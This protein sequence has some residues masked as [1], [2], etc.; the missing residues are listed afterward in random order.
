MADRAILPFTPPNMTTILEQRLLS[1]VHRVPH[2]TAR[3]QDSSLPAGTPETT[4]PL[5]FVAKILLNPVFST[6]TMH[7]MRTP[8]CYVAL[9]SHAKW[10]RIS[11]SGASCEQKCRGFAAPLWRLSP[12]RTEG[13]PTF[14]FWSMFQA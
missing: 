13:W 9:V 10:T 8:S 4:Y 7:N 3:V 14:K 5:Q 6:P 2:V 12:L 1:S 11:V